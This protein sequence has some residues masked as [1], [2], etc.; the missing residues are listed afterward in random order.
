MQA[1]EVV[2]MA[3]YGMIVMIGLLVLLLLFVVWR[4]FFGRRQPPVSPRPEYNPVSAERIQ[5]AFLELQRILEQQPLTGSVS[6][7]QGYPDARQW[8]VLLQQTPQEA[9]DLLE[10]LR[11][12]MARQGVFAD[13]VT[14]DSIIAYEAANKYLQ[15]YGP[16]HTI[17]TEPAPTLATHIES[18]PNE[19]EWRRRLSE[20]RQAALRFLYGLELQRARLGFKT[21]PMLEA[22]IAAFQRA[23]NTASGENNSPETRT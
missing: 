9:A 5:H 23:A 15:T 10:A 3:T 18:Y 8:L 1:T 16:I 14:I 4:T 11:M 22:S 17:Q 7:H 19:Q 21:S 6:P 13:F 12:Q 20:N 2:A